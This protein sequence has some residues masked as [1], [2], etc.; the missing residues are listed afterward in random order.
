VSGTSIET[1]IK[2]AS[3]VEGFIVFPNTLSLGY[4]NSKWTL[5]KEN[6]HF[7]DHITGQSGAS[8]S[9]CYTTDHGKTWVIDWIHLDES[10]YPFGVCIYSFL[11]I[12]SK[13]QITNQFQAAIIIFKKHEEEARWTIIGSYQ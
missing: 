4:V 12:V 5:E 13:R 2:L 10:Y 11:I 6:M 9:N 7:P 1:R 8:F 3:P